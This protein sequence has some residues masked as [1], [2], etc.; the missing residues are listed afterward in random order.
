MTS[1]L[2]AKKSN[3]RRCPPRTKVGAR[4]ARALGD[5][6]RTKKR[7]LRWSSKLVFVVWRG[8]AQQLNVP[9]GAAARPER[10]TAPFAILCGS[11]PT[12]HT[13]PKSGGIWWLLS[14]HPLTTSR[15]RAPTTRR[16]RGEEVEILGNRVKCHPMAVLTVL[17]SKYRLILRSS[18][19][20]VTSPDDTILSRTPS[21]LDTSVRSGSPVSVA[22]LSPVKPRGHHFFQSTF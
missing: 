15:A 8:N 6:T 3:D 11:E 17:A 7:L 19:N 16:G 14:N 20:F 12:V 10:T 1:S 5:K 21:P 9:L 22:M 2:Q 13:C 18:R 4:E